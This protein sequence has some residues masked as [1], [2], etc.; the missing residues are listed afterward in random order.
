VD[1]LQGDVAFIKLQLLARQRDFSLDRLPDTDS[2]R[3]AGDFRFQP[4]SRLVTKGP[5]QDFEPAQNPRYSID[6]SY[7]KHRHQHRELFVH[8]F[9]ALAEVE[10]NSILERTCAGVKAART[11]GRS[12]GRPGRRPEQLQSVQKRPETW[13]DYAA[14]AVSDRTICRGEYRGIDVAESSTL[15][16]PSLYNKACSL[17]GVHDDARRVPSGTRRAPCL[18]SDEGPWDRLITCRSPIGNRKAL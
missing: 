10:G 9:G 14:L 7:R 15:G 11:R 2:D 4:R 13:Q 8:I 6:L 1:A 5:N 18:L 3:P 16:T 12:G 17:H